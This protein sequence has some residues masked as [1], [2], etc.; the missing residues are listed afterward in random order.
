MTSGH[1][2][3]ILISLGI[4][5]LAIVATFIFFPNIYM[6]ALGVD[7]AKN[8]SAS[9]PAPSVELPATGSPGAI[10]E[11]TPEKSDTP[12]QNS[13][14][15][16]TTETQPNIASV[17]TDST[18]DTPQNVLNSASPASPVVN[19]TAEATPSD[20]KVA[21]GKLERGDTAGSLLS[22]YLSPSDIKQVESMSQEIYPLSRLQAGKPF[23][24]VTSKGQ[25]IRFEYQINNLN[26]LIIEKKKDGFD[27]YKKTVPY[28]VEV[29]RIEGQIALSLFTAVE[30]I[31]EGP[32]LAMKLADIFAWEI[33]FIRDI[34]SGD[35]FSAIVE[36]RYYKG[37]FRDYGRILAARFV[38][39]GEEHEGFFYENA[40]GRPGYYNAEGKNLR[41]AFLKVPLSFTRISSRFSWNRLH[42]VLHIYRPH[43]GV[44]Y[45]APTGTPVKA[46]GDAVVVSAG[47]NRGGGR[48]VHLRHI[49]G[50]Q[51]KYLHLSRFGRGIKKGAEVKQGQVIGYVG[52]S[53]L[54]TGP[55]LDFRVMKGGKYINPTA[56]KNPRA[57]SLTTAEMV[58]FRT[59][60]L[61]FE[62]R[63]KNKNLK[64]DSNFAMQNGLDDSSL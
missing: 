10:T 46:I 4:G 61:K 51:S 23:S 59:D 52:S 32:E 21:K 49:N 9:Q 29:S 37:K 13:T 34:R 44:D 48:T 24:I 1:F 55:H 53:G 38:N 35:S 12:I 31:G 22:E 20:K 5:S 64:V 17:P 41:K 54:A 26:K 6:K 62:A 28:K 45:A 58:D 36:K 43:L 57:D 19:A 40:K 14:A 39:N 15:D 50:Y 42:P 11:N 7:S 8:E 47:W 60:S 25:F 30:S 27:V 56:M 3:Q 16:T 33:D 63:L 2:K 18:T